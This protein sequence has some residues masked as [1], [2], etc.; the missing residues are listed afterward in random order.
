MEETVA[1]LL[2][3]KAYLCYSR[4]ARILQMYAELHNHRPCRCAKAKHTRGLL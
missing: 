4:V 3:D 2:T 1:K